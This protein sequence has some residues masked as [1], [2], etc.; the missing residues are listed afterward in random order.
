MYYFSWFF[1][2]SAY[3][4]HQCSRGCHRHWSSGLG[5]SLQAV[6]WDSH[7]RGCCWASCPGEW[8]G[9]WT[10]GGG[11]ISLEQCQRWCAT[12]LAN[13]T[14]GVGDV[15]NNLGFHWAC[16]RTSKASRLQRSSILT[17]EQDWHASLSQASPSP[18]KILGLLAMLRSPAS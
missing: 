6:G 14:G 7:P 18:R 5:Q 11:N 12:V 9:V 16:T 4:R 2:W 17:A 1:M 13:P 8:R 3:L 15:T 10:C